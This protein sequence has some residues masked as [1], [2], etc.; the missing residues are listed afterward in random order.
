MKPSGISGNK[1]GEY[2][3]DKIDEI[4]TNIRNERPI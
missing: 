2:L 1:K 3:K 4:A